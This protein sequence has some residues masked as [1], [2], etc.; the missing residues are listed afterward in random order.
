MST[1]HC[2]GV[3]FQ[4]WPGSLGT[5]YSGYREAGSPWTHFDKHLVGKR[6]V[7]QVP[8]SRGGTK[9]RQ[10]APFFCQ[11]P[12]HLKLGGLRQN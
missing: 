4:G 9:Q 6:G 8:G 1:P 12:G 2:G 10:S 11:G 5:V 7:L 3:R